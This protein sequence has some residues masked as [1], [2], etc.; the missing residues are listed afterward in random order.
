MAEWAMKF[1]YI[2]FTLFILFGCGPSEEEI[3]RERINLERERIN[4]ERE[5]IN[6]E[7]NCIRLNSELFYTNALASAEESYR[8]R[9]ELE[10]ASQ[11]FLRD[12][13][14]S[15]PASSLELPRTTASNKR[16]AKLPF[17]RSK[18]KEDPIYIWSK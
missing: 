6:L 12:L 5:R 7:Q 1:F 17:F 11:Q 9:R 8:L 15:V 18:C 14:H 10:R 16:S 3:E 4:L 13:G 2:L